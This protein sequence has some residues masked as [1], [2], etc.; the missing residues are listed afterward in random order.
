MVAMD[1]NKQQK[2]GETENRQGLQKS[3][4]MCFYT[5]VYEGKS[6]LK[7]ATV[8]AWSVSLRHPIKPPSFAHALVAQKPDIDKLIMKLAKQ[9][10][11]A[12]KGC[13]TTQEY[14]KF[15]D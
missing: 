1:I 5:G 3:D 13:K 6:V 14:V 8:S 9:L 12:E 10:E 4:D 15:D 2:R 11:R 7:K